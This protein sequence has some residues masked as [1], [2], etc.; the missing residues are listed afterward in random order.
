VEFPSKK[1][2]NQEAANK[3]KQILPGPKLKA[4]EKNQANV[5]FL[6]D[7]LE[8]DLN[9]NPEG[10]RERDE[11]DEGQGHPGGGQRVQCQQ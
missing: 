10:G 9:P 2:L 7:Y 1:D 6:S 8:A 11:D 5:E 4:L 3:L